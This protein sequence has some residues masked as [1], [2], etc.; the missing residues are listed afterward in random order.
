[1]QDFKKLRVW[2]LAHELALEVIEALPE[3][4]SR[5]VPGLRNQAIRAATSVTANIAEGCGA[6][7]RLGFL[8][9]IEIAVASLNELEG[10]LSLAHDA[11]VILDSA[12]ARLQRK[13]ELLRRMLV[14]LMRTLHRHI[15]EDAQRCK[16]CGVS[17]ER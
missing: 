5:K 6:A 16:A 10:E 1:M 7:T 17:D 11:H 9:F 2:H 15:A 8:N 4:S 14:A 13:L 12:H 3:R